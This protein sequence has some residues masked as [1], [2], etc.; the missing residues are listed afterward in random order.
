VYSK[1]LRVSVTINVDKKDMKS[2]SVTVGSFI[3]MVNV[4]SGC[5]KIR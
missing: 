2:I 5:L 3:V 4:L 1:D